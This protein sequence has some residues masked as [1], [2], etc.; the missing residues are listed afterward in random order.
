MMAPNTQNNM[1]SLSSA[2]AVV[3]GYSTSVSIAVCELPAFYDVLS[4][5][6]F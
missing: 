5:R 3:N 2:G 4:S 1:T 6:S